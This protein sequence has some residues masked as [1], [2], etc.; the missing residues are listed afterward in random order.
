MG[1]ETRWRVPHMASDTAVALPF[2]FTPTI[3]MVLADLPA[4]ALAAPPCAP[5]QRVCRRYYVRGRAVNATGRGEPS[6]EVTIEVR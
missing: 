4:V 6:N 5:R 3:A 1:Y 2:D